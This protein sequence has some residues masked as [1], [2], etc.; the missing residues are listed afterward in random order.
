MSLRNY[1]R[2]AID[3]VTEEHAAGVAGQIISIPTSAGKTHIAANLPYRGSKLFLVGAEELVWQAQEKLQFIN[4][5]LM[6][7][8]E[9]ADRQADTS[10]HDII[11]ASVP[12][13]ARKKRLARFRPDSFRQIGVDECH[14]TTK[15][16]MYA[17]I[18]RHFQALKS[19]SNYDPSTL[20]Y[21]LTAT[22]NR[23][24][25]QG[26]EHTFSKITFQRS[27]LDLMR[28]GITINDKLYPYIAD[29]VCHRV[30]TYADL[31]PV[32][33]K[34]RDLNQ[35]DLANAIDTP[36]RNKIALDS[37]LKLGRGLGAFGFT[38]NI[39]HGHNLAKVFNDGGVPAAVM[40]G[41]TTREE[42]KVLFA[43]LE[44][45]SLK[46]IF[47][48]GVLGEGIDQPKVTV[49]LMLRPTK[50]QLLFQQQA[51]RIL[52]PYPAPEELLR[53]FKAG[54]ER[55]WR[56]KHAI[57]IDFVDQSGR[58]SL[59]QTPTLFGLRHDFDMDGQSA[60]E[61]AQQVE[62]LEKLVAVDVRQQKS[63]YEIKSLI[64][65]VDLLKP[66]VTPP[67]I[68]RWSKYPWLETAPGKYALSLNG[69]R[70][71]RV[72]ILPSGSFR[73]SFYTN[74]LM[75][76]RGGESTLR[77]AIATA[78]GLIPAPEARALKETAAWH[79]EPPTEQQC[80][81]LFSLDKKNLAVA[82]KDSR[83]FWIFARNEYYAGNNTYSSG[84]IA[85]LIDSRKLARPVWLQQK[86]AAIKQRYVTS[87]RR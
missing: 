37:Y 10:R 67:E 28:T 34:D 63:I 24:D 58:H 69:N 78:E 79:R 53:R 29:I 13:L 57:L 73:V 86:I 1:Q 16:G 46:V 62:D 76:I 65:Q 43:A 81:Y 31:S 22:P 3:T 42:R 5:D 7:G 8:V 60:L 61:V 14:H 20:L 74:G 55:G 17:D 77:S 33:T 41:G 6:I 19:E 56:K 47:S 44:E 87:D 71:V 48:T 52:R 49:G 18:L 23:A 68:R 70:S 39:A 32:H 11:I 85:K 75:Q 21:G 36:E 4:P 35:E 66:P 84:G 15:S 54:E 2:E 45:G 59:I 82:H 51:G 9:K 80:G 50:S 83:E 30:D 38:V 26:L 27:L 40:H 12:S 64:E 72:T 25:G